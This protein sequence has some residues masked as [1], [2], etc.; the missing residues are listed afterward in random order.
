MNDCNH[1]ELATWLLKWHHGLE[2][3]EEEVKKKEEKAPL[4]LFML[5]GVDVGK[6]YTVTA[7]ANG[8]YEQGWTV[9]VVDADVGQSDIGP[10]CCIGMGM[11]ERAIKKLSDVPPL[12]LYF[13]GNT[14]PAGCMR[15]CVQGAAAGVKKAKG[16]DVIIVD[17]T[18]WI[19]GD[20]AMRFK[21]LEVKE[22][23]PSF[24]VAIENEDELEHIVPHLTK[25]VITLRRSRV[26][27][28]RTR[29]ER[30]ALREDAYNRYF[31][32]AEDRVFELAL[33][34][35][36]PEAGTILGL[37]RGKSENDEVAGLGIV[38]KLDYERGEAVVFTPVGAGGDIR[39][40]RIKSGLVRLTREKEEFKEFFSFALN[41]Q[42]RN[43]HV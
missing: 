23:D 38:R 4:I 8:F 13:V 5:G 1:R 11:L 25:K 6:T 20:D 27:R 43:G 21:L 19:A 18:G 14:S 17:S 30:R 9:A 35:R 34:D 24:V 26:A 28:S 31:K 36:I 33:F 16:A 32:D 29:E 22:I 3:S 39:I 42:R 10:P 40:K 2:L 41:H 12:C 37:F 7:I 15:E